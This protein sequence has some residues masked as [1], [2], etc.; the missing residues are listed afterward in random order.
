MRLSSPYIQGALEEV[1][2]VPG[3]NSKAPAAE[4]NTKP[5]TGTEQVTVGPAGSAW[6]KHGHVFNECP[7]AVAVCQESS[8]VLGKHQ[9]TGQTNISALWSSHFSGGK[10]IGT[11]KSSDISEG[12]SAIKNKGGESERTG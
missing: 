7:L 3:V 5:I 10:L 2:A 4:T 1:S 12:M 9:R 6:T 11:K 8:W